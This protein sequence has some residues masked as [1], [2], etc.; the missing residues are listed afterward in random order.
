MPFD[1]WLS[2]WSF[3][4]AVKTKQRY[5]HEND[6]QNFL[7]T[8]LS[9]LPSRIKTIEEGTPLWRAQKG[10]KKDTQNDDIPMPFLAERMK[11]LK[12]K[13]KE[14]RANPKGI[15][16]LYLATNQKTAISEV[17]PWVGSLIS[18]ANFMVSNRLEIID[19]TSDEAYLPIYLRNDEPNDITKE[20]H[21]W[22]DINKAFSDP[23][24][25]TDDIADYVPTQILSEL[26]KTNGYDGIEYSS[27]LADGN[28]IVLFDLNNATP[29]H[30]QLHKVVSL[31]VEHEEDANPIYFNSDRD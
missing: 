1:S 22:S 27:R 18:L 14:G 25:Q 13:A 23:V 5:I 8:V 9:T 7:D 12:D 10:Y 4:A 31:N 15:P 21:V 2:Y 30:C 26:F 11:P 19:C 20:M 6:T 17:R 29:V 3:A 28:N 24:D 16:Y